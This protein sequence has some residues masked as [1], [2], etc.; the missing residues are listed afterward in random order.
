MKQK[1]KRS[2]HFKKT[3]QKIK[4]LN[5]ILYFNKSYFSLVLPTF[6]FPL[7]FTTNFD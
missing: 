5:L 3:K 2:Y 4:E 7:V 6:F 1:L